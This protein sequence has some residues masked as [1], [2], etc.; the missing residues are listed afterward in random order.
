MVQS[1]SKLRHAQTISTSETGLYHSIPTDSQSPFFGV[2]FNQ[3]FQHHKPP[4]MV[5]KKKKKKKRLNGVF[6]T[7]HGDVRESLNLPL[8]ISLKTCCWKKYVWLCWRFC[9]V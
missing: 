3:G 7:L 1:K 9:N 2:C 8:F 4:E 6:L 5:G